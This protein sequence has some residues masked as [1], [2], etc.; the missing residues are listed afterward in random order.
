[1]V[2][3]A[4]QRKTQR[5]DGGHA[6]RRGG[7]VAGPL[8]RRQPFAEGAYGGIGEPRVDVA[9][10]RFGEPCRRFG[11]TGEDEARGGEDG[12]VVLAFDA[13]FLEPGPP[14]LPRMIALTQKPEFIAYGEAKKA[15]EAQDWAGLCVYQAANAALAASGKRPDVVFMG[16]SITEN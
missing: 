11:G 7:A 16:D 5:G 4:Q 14:D 1:M 12:V 3:A 8:E 2:T 13:A 9:R 15:R 6:G 10:R